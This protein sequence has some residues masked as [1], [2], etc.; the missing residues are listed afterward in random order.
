LIGF[1]CMDSMQKFRTVRQAS[2]IVADTGLSV[3]HYAVFEV[4]LT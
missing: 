4:L 2:A 1:L 3:L